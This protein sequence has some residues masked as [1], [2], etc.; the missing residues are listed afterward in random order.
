M[1]I[2]N[3]VRVATFEKQEEPVEVAGVYWGEDLQGKN[4]KYHQA[5]LVKKDKGGFNW[6]IIIAMIAY[7]KNSGIPWI[8]ALW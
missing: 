1:K 4:E 6:F 8:E 7:V 2:M 3:R 5:R